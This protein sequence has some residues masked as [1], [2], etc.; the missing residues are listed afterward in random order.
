[1]SFTEFINQINVILF[2]NPSS[3][4][5]LILYTILNWFFEILKWKTLV[6]TLKKITFYEA[7]KQSLASLTTSLFTPNRIGE[8][9]AK[10]IYFLKQKRKIMLLNLIGNLNQLA[11]TIIFGII[12]L[13]Y[14][15]T[16]YNINFSIHNLR[17]IGFLVA[18]IVLIPLSNRGKSL[19]LFGFFE[20]EKIKNFI[21]KINSKT[22]LKIFTF[23]VI[24][25]IIFSHQFLFLLRLFGV[26]TDYSILMLLI[27]S[28][29]FIASS[30][31]S[32][33]LFDWAI[34][35]SVAIFIFSFIGIQETTIVTVTLLMWILNFAIPA[36]FGSFFVLNF[37]FTEE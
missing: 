11:V 1:M 16:T 30:I 37:K 20:F 4:F 15:L 12:G 7:A 25:Y 23:S 24:R 22:H 21:K 26:E 13:I 6:S 8:Y 32:I 9:G 27:F 29:Y 18:F 14:F 36:V 35:G 2:R 31:P 34:K 17:R 33:A 3:I 19:K 10:A 28:T 5:I